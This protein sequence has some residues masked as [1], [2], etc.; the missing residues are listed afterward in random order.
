MQNRMYRWIMSGLVTALCCANSGCS[1]VT[2]GPQVRTQYVVLHPGKPMQA[3]ENVK[4]KGRVLNAGGTEA[5]VGDTVE[6]DVG[7]WIFMP[8]DHWDAVK[9]QLEKQ[10]NKEN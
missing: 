7:G 4:V 1:S 6:Q 8:Q 5:G 3:L 9:R 2:L 10:P